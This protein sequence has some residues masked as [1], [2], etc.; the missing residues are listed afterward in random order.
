[1]FSYRVTGEF[2]DAGKA[3]IAAA[4]PAQKQKNSY[5][6]STK[7]NVANEMPFPHVEADD[8]VDGQESQDCLF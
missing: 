2:K 6:K 1:L 3:T 4:T 8:W 7:D 5:V